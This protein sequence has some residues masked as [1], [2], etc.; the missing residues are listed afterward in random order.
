MSIITQED[1]SRVMESVDIVEVARRMGKKV[2]TKGKNNFV[3]CPFH[4]DSEG[5][6]GSCNLHPETNTFKCFGC[7]CKGNV[8]QFYCQLLGMP[9]RGAGSHF[10]KAVEELHRMFNLPFE[11]RYGTFTADSIRNQSDDWLN[12]LHPLLPFKVENMTVDLW[13]ISTKENLLEMPIFLRE[14]YIPI[15]PKEQKLKYPLLVAYLRDIGCLALLE[16]KNFKLRG[17]WVMKKKNGNFICQR[18]PAKLMRGQELSNESWEED[19]VALF[20]TRI[21]VENPIDYAILAAHHIPVSWGIWGLQ[22]KNKEFLMPSPYSHGYRIPCLIALHMGSNP[23]ST[24]R[25]RKTLDSGHKITWLPREVEIYTMDSLIDQ[26]DDHENLMSLFKL[27]HPIEDI[28][29]V[30]V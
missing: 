10:P 15:V 17:I 6:G 22:E 29:P 21:A 30:F 24:Q 27:S 7:A 14:A 2:T 25:F 16:E 20:E 4:T 5:D 3:Q 9:C 12:S 28:R 26:K 13:R 11:L 8:F 18:N 23:T 19:S 1:I